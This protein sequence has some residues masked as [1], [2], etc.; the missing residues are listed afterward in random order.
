MSWSVTSFIILFE[1]DYYY[2]LLATLNTIFMK[3]YIISNQTILEVDTVNI[4]FNKLS[5]GF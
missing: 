2:S 1:A 5:N 3:R 4:V